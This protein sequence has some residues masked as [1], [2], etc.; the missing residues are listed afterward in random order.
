MKG[1]KNQYNSNPIVMQILDAY[2]RAN[3]WITDI[4]YLIGDSKAT[5]LFC[6]WQ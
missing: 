1:E 6:R 4:R 2:L 5:D 3:P